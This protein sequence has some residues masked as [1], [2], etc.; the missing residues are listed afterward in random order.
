MK[1]RATILLNTTMLSMLG[2]SVASLVAVV[3]SV[4]AAEADDIVVTLS[5]IHI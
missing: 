5:L 2:L 3:P 4:H 1:S